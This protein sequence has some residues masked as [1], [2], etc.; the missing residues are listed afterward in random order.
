MS[1]IVTKMSDLKPPPVEVHFDMNNNGVSYIDIK[2]REGYEDYFIE[3]DRIKDDSEILHWVKHLCQ[4]NWMTT[5]KLQQFI[6]NMQQYNKTF[7]E[8]EEVECL[9]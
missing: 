6:N 1:F 9:S 8:S 4:K 5:W 2:T 3:L 7:K